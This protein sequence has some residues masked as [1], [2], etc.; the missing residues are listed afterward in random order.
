MYLFLLSVKMSLKMCFFSFFFTFLFA[1]F[2][3][4]L[5]LRANIRKRAA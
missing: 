4:F 5:Y 2:R 1:P 3:N